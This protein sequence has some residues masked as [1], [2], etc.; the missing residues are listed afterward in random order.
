[1]K[2]NEIIEEFVLEQIEHDLN[3]SDFTALSELITKLLEN[4]YSNE[5]L[6]INYLDFNL[7]E[8][9]I[10]ELENILKPCPMCGA[11]KPKLKNPNNDNKEEI[12]CL[13][14]GLKITR[15]IGCNVVDAWNK[16]TK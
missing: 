6:L 8:N 2:R 11:E 9:L 7:K 10:K 12:Q 1:M 16:R 3:T 15:E 14:C 5:K 4:K 13:N